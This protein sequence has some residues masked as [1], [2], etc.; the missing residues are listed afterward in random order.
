MDDGGLSQALSR[1]DRAVARI[2]AALADVDATRG[3]D[4]QLRSK[5]RD[6]IAELD[7]L[8]QTAGA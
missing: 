8:I 6:A 2:E 4:E 7:Q 1:A 5:V 3:Q